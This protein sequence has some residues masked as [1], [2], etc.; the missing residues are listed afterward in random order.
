MVVMLS[1]VNQIVNRTGMLKIG[2]YNRLIVDRVVDFGLYLKIGDHEI[3]LPSKYIPDKCRL[4]DT[5]RVF[6]YTDSEDRPI[7]TTLV[8]K[9]AVGEFACLRVNDV[10]SFGAF[11]DWGLEKDLLLPKSEQTNRVRVGQRIVVKVCLDEQTGRVYGTNRIEEN[12]TP[13]PKRLSEG[14]K[15]SLLIYA[16]TKIGI[17]AVVD[18]RY[19]GMLYRNEIFMPL[20]IGDSVE[21][22]I[23]KIRKDG[24]IDLTLKKPGYRSIADS[25]DSVMEVL[26]KQGGFIPCHDKSPPEEIKHIFSMSKKEFKKAVGRLYKSG[27]I[28][29]TDRGI[30]V[31]RRTR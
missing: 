28:D 3:L 9:A 12:C 22:Y 10:K 31:K 18:N 8:P 30:Q 25:S 7:A 11:L 20:S 17:M 15:V 21:G 6:V 5:L 27:K 2:Q 1:M 14:Q 16:I 26:V 19:A 23:R 4:G 29:L 24:K 13:I